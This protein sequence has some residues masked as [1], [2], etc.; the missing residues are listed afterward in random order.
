MLSHICTCFDSCL[1][2]YSDFRSLELGVFSCVRMR[3]VVVRS[4]YV[5]L[6]AVLA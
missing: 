5:E 6:R 2:D 1:M 3:V 4:N